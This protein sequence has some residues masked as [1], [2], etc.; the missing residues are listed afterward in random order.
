[1]KRGIPVEKPSAYVSTKLY[2]IR[3][4]KGVSQQKLSE[5]SG[6]SKRAVQSYEQRD[7]DIDSARLSVLCDLSKALDCKISDIIENEE[8]LKKYILCR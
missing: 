5:L 1:M 3:L 6:V 8:L 4:E 2:K 7:R